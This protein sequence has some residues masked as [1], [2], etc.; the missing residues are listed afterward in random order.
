M[1]L[2]DSRWHFDD[3]S[4]PP[5]LLCNISSGGLKYE[6]GII[7]RP[8]YLTR[9]W[10]WYECQDA[11]LR[12]SDEGW[13]IRTTGGGNLL[14]DRGQQIT[15][16]TALTVQSA[17]TST[18]RVQLN[19][20]VWHKVGTCPSVG[21]KTEFYTIKTVDQKLH[22]CIFLSRKE[23]FHENFSSCWNYKPLMDYHL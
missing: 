16:V 3:I 22:S 15:R 2:G 13:W 21:P 19:A 18:S 6:S 5:F 1:S 11:R 20:T 7:K 12:V 10:R 23:H 17:D 14:E 9:W 4:Q 8:H